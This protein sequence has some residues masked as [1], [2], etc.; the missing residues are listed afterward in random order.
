MQASPIT[1]G[2]GIWH[3]H[4]SPLVIEISEHLILGLRLGPSRRYGPPF[5]VARSVVS[6][7]HQRRLKFYCSPARALTHCLVPVPSR[8]CELIQYLFWLLSWPHYSFIHTA[9]PETV[10][11]RLEAWNNQLASRQ[12]LN[13][14][15]AAFA[16]RTVSTLFWRSSRQPGSHSQSGHCGVCAALRC[17]ARRDAECS[18]PVTAALSVKRPN[19]LQ[20]P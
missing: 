20:P 12:Q 14:S 10:I 9:S 7:R 13:C 5:A 17:T 4:P 1:R 8:H 16:H 11:P 3:K 2:H 18:S 6:T 19:V 15:F